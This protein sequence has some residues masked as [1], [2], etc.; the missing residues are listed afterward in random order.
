MQNDNNNFVFIVLDA[1]RSDH[2]NDDYMPFLSSLKGRSIFVESLNVS[3]GFCE[4]AEILFGQ[5]PRESGFVH[6][7]SPHSDVKPYAWLSARKAKFLELFEFNLILKKVLR[8]LL[9]KLSIFFGDGMYPQRIPLSVLRKFG[10]TED[11]V[12]FEEYSLKLKKGLL[13]TIISRGFKV[14]WKFFTSLSSTLLSSDSQR[15]QDVPKYLAISGNQFLP[16][17]IGAPDE[18]GHKFGPHSSGL[19]VKLGDLD[20]EL[21]EF[22]RSCQNIDP[23][24]TL[25]FVGDH[26]MELVTTAIDLK[27]EITSMAI[28]HNVVEGLDYGIFV[29]STSVRFWFYENTA[30]LSSFLAAIRNNKLFCEFGYFLDDELCRVEN[31]PPVADIADL[32]WWAAK[33][34]QV[35]PDYFHDDPKGKLGMHGY[36]KIDDISSGFV[37]CASSNESPVYLKSCECHELSRILL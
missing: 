30:S 5:S 10:F 17:Y 6:A 20:K 7:I 3:S 9:W 22:Y 28:S 24:V 15:L 14:D 16:V 35:A 26:G 33:G 34:T 18:Y 12:D 2:V 19:I 27:K 1:L 32:V 4:R 13:F 21:E 11:S 36:L 23:D 29:D 31:L 8:R 37:I 25:C